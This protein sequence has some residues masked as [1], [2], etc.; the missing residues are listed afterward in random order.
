MSLQYIRIKG[1]KLESDERQ[2]IY[3][4]SQTSLWKEEGYEAKKFLLNRGLDPETIAK[5]RL[6]YIP[7]NNYTNNIRMLSERVVIPIYDSY[8]N[9]IALSFRPIVNDPDVLKE[10]SKYWNESYI[11]GDHLFGLNFAK[12]AIIKTGFAI[13]VEGQ[14]DVISM[15]SFGFTNTI[16]VLGGAFTPSQALLIR[17]WTDQIVI[18]FDADKAGRDHTH[19][20]FE[21]LD[22]Y[23]FK[24]MNSKNGLSSSRCLRAV[25]AQ[26]PESSDPNDFLKKEGSNS[27]R[28][29]IKRDMLKA[30]MSYIEEN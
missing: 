11:K 26:L 21:V 7:D 9:L 13:L 4:A 14:M 3:G 27:M 16:G 2:L 20:A 6:G 8:D 24:F 10:Y 22:A 15:H 23:G 29:L 18:M 25:V 1:A 12:E 28:A 5:F 19:K 17:R 30:D